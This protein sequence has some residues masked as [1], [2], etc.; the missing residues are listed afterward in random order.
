VRDILFYLEYAELPYKSYRVKISTEG[1][2][3][4]VLEEDGK[5]IQDYVNGVIDSCAQLKSLA[6]INKDNE[7][8]EGIYSFRRFSE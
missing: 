2:V 3:V 8:V 7:T 6:A 4:A 1:S 5:L